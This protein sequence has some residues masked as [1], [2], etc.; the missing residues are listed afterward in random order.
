MDAVRLARLWKEKDENG[1]TYLSGKLNAI[2]AILVMPNTDKKGE[3]PDY[4]LYLCQTERGEA[5]HGE[6]EKA[7]GEETTFK[8]ECRP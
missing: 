2:S 6:Y 4:F 1:N 3:E 8:E 5:G 7:K